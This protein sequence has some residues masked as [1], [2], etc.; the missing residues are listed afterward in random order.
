MGCACGSRDCRGVVR[1]FAS[2][3]MERQDWYRARNIVAPYL[4][5]GEAVATEWA[6]S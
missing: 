1:A 3:P 5:A 4:R 2:L 6:A